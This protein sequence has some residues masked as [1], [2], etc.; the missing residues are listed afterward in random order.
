MA[1]LITNMGEGVGLMIAG[2]VHGVTLS[3]GTVAAEQIGSV[4]DLLDTNGNSINNPLANPGAIVG[5]V[6]VVNAGLGSSGATG[7]TD[8]AA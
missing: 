7:V 1:S 5:M 3:A 6:F 8:T 2:G 4:V